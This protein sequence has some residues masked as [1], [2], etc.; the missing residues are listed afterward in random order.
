MNAPALADMVE[1]VQALT[2]FIA[3]HPAL[4]PFAQADMQEEI[5]TL[6]QDI[7]QITSQVA[8]GRAY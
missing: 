7:A 6:K 5:N 8:T 2:T 4:Q 1:L 3:Q